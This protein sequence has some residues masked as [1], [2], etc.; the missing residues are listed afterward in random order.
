MVLLC[1]AL[2]TSLLAQEFS[3]GTATARRGEI[4]YGA[5]EVP[6]GSDA[7]T[8]IPVAVINGARDGRVSAFIAGSHGTEYASTVALTRLISRIDPK[9]LSG[10]VV[11]APLLNVASFEQM[12]V[13][14]NPI[15]KKGMN[16]QYPGD[17]SGTQTQR[18][19]A[20]VTE[21]IVKRADVIVDLHGGDLDEDL[22][23]Y[24]Y[25]I[26]TGN[27]AQDS[28]SR[29][30]ALAFGLDRIIVNDIDVS[31]P[32]ST[33]SLS[34]YSLSL[35]KTVLV[36]EAGYSGRVEA[37]DVNR[38]VDGCLN[39]LQGR[40][41]TGATPIWL[42]SGTRLRAEAPGMWSP[43]VRGGAYV[44]AGMRLGTMTDYL[45]RNAKEIRSPAAGIVTFIR[46]V[47]SVWKDATL[48]NVSP[49]LTEPG[50][51]IKPPR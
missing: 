28:A 3:V 22:V 41:E 6:A 11:V 43:A 35:G 8:T 48:V 7:G 19:L 34:G 17:A 47:P 14:L 20:I 30:L 1:F 4:A 9:T 25:W 37:D 39:V 16:A 27:A 44:T 18:A 40:P 42:G 12:T 26:R 21:Q 5:L 10:T 33:R 13:H 45:G 46:G 2:S 24:S 38:L 23:P 51:Y 50:P 15:D 49:V 31:N 29:S 32:A 36:A